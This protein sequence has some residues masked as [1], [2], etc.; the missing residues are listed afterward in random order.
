MNRYY[1]FLTVGALL[2]VIFLGVYLL[3]PIYAP[4]YRDMGKNPEE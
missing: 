2:I 4:H 1:L 3:T